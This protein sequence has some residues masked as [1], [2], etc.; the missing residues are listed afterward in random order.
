MAATGSPI[1]EQNQEDNLTTRLT[2]TEALKRYALRENDLLD[3]PCITKKNKHGPHPMKLYLVTDLETVACKRYGNVEA[4]TAESLRRENR[5]SE[6]RLKRASEEQEFDKSKR[7]ILA[8]PTGD[9]LPECLAERVAGPSNFSICGGP[10]NVLC[11]LQL[12]LRHDNNPALQVAR[13]RARRL[14]ASLTVVC[15]LHCMTL[16]H[17]K[18]ELECYAD[19]RQELLCR[20]VPT[21]LAVVPD[22]GVNV[23]KDLV[24]AAQHVVAD[25]VLT[26][27]FIT[28]LR[29]VSSECR[30]LE[31][32][33][34]S[35]LV[36]FRCAEAQRS[37]N[38]AAHAFRRATE[39]KRK[40]ALAGSRLVAELDALD[41]VLFPHASNNQED[42]T[43][44]AEKLADLAP[45][46]DCAVPPL[47]TIRG[48][49]AWAK[50]R[51]IQYRDSASGLR[52]YASRRNN[53][54][55]V[56][57]VSRLSAHLH[58][59]A[60]SVFQI[61]RDAAALGADKY[62]DELLVWR[63]LSHA[64]AAKFESL[65]TSSPY[66]LVPNWAKHTLA[67]HLPDQRPKLLS[68]A[69]L[70]SAN[71]GDRLWDAAQRCLLRHGELHNNLRM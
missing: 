58:Y 64:F 67:S 66:S 1:S 35:C 52:A 65:L 33:D 7:L 9:D 24:Q 55:A 26:P 38:S 45:K 23:L 42:S 3:V 61:S 18:F 49:T 70:E 29:D 47:S 36:P 46:I 11:V 44:V 39:A 13:L 59:G 54:L 4:A 10:G 41:T 12:A 69:E 43:W 21:E 5:R 63:E 15:A 20:N 27:P 40:N 8:H 6:R 28:L 34:S 2:K 32:V 30:A 31:R 57:S 16:R 14:N 53:A 56:D 71:S 37:C 22:G 60:A 68:Y 48:G 17:A 51:W 25:D 50:R 19:L 62:I